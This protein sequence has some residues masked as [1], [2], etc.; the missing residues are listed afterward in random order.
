MAVCMGRA[1]RTMRFI[2]H[3][4]IR[5]YLTGRLSA[6]TKNIPKPDSD[7]C[8]KYASVSELKIAIAVKQKSQATRTAAG[9]VA[10]KLM[11]MFQA[12]TEQCY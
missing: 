11:T 12:F 5:L 4:I 3:C 2:P 8:A 7:P 6:K 1:T 10:F 9:P